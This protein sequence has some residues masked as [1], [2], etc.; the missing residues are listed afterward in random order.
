MTDSL[1][2]VGTCNVR[3]MA[4]RM[5]A[6]MDMAADAHLHILCL[7]ETKLRTEGIHRLSGPRAGALCQAA[8]GRTLRASRM[9]EWL[10]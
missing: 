8:F 5:G 7:Q 9:V 1:L 6:I 10:L 4:G 3:T 2:R